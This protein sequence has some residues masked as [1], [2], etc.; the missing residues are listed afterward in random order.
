M[1]VFGIIRQLFAL[2]NG[3]KMLEISRILAKLW[4]KTNFYGHNG[5][6]AIK[7]PRVSYV[8]EIVTSSDTFGLEA[9]KFPLFSMLFLPFP[10]NLQ[11]FKEKK[12]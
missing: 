1:V 8:N 3:I 9:R 6:L 11:K 4:P 5:Y 7:S 10:P 12:L 2:S